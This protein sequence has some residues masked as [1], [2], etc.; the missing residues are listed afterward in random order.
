[1]TTLSGEQAGLILID[2]HAGATDSGTTFV[3]ARVSSADQRMDLDNAMI[4]LPLAVATP[5]F[6]GEPLH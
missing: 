1:V 6:V 4:L 2:R 5:M 3:Y